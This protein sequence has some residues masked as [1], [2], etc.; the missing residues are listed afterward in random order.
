MVEVVALL[1]MDRIGLPIQAD[2]SSHHWVL[3][4]R[5]YLLERLAVL[6]KRYFHFKENKKS[7]KTCVSTKKLP[8]TELKIGHVRSCF[9]AEVR[10]TLR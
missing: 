9:L 4:I 8:P 5:I 6:C 7:K 10:M 2:S 3:S 1:M